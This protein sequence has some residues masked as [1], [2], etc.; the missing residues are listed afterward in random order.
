M[1]NGPNYI[2]K[3]KANFFGDIINIFGPGYNPKNAFS[4]K[5]KRRELYATVKYY[6]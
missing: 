1:E 6:S 5:L 4:K 3:I 2:G